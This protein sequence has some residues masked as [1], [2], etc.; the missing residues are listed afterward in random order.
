MRFVHISSAF[1]RKGVDV[2]LDAYFSTF[3]NSDDVTLVLKTFPNPHNEVGDLLKQ[4][5][6]AHPSPPDVRWIDR[7]LDAE[8]IMGLYN[9]ADCYV[10]PAAR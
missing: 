8:E 3:S 10:H 4:M 7:D 2:L 9:L 6:A 1:P 5:R